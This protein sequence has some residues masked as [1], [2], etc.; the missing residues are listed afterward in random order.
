MK[1]IKTLIILILTAVAAH[2]D[3]IATVDTT[4]G[5]HT[6]GSGATYYGDTAKAAFEKVNG[7]FV[8]IW[9]IVSNGITGV[10]FTNTLTL[11][12]GSSATAAVVGYASHTA[13]LQLGIP[14]G[15]PGTNFVTVFDPTNSILSSRRITTYSTNNITWGTSN[16]LAYVPGLSD[17]AVSFGQLGAVGFTPGTNVYGTLNG[18]YDGTSWFSISNTFQTTNWIYVSAMGAGG[19]LGSCILYSIDQLVLLGRTNYFYGQSMQFDSPRN[20]S[21]ASTKK[22]VDDQVGALKNTTFVLS[23]DTNNVVHYAYYGGGQTMQ[24]DLWYQFSYIPILS[25][26]L[27]GSTFTNVLMD[28][29]QTNLPASFTI[30]SSTNLNLGSVGF[31]PF[32]NYTLSTNS[33]IVTFTI[34]IYMSEPM[35]FWRAISGSKSGITAN[36]PIQANAGAIFYRTNAWTAIEITNNGGFAPWLSNYTR[37]WWSVN[38][39]NVIYNQ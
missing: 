13:I 29:Y 11:S 12:P 7:N 34:P 15:T 18:S 39:N 14:K 9:G 35:R 6:S 26:A 4:S 17:Y 24:F 23:T 8:L 20:D 19:G 3:T 36:R 31:V 28:I 33:G 27:D 32:T 10:T 37:V 21:D 5:P 30:Q 22:Y 25:L 1:T 38:S 16:Y 2:A